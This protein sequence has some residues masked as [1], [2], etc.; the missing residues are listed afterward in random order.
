MKY[1]LMPGHIARTSGATMLQMSPFP[2]FDDWRDENGK[3]APR[4]HACGRVGDPGYD[5]L[6]TMDSEG[7]LQKYS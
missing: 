7:M 5:L 6:I 4:T 3:M 2:P 1:R